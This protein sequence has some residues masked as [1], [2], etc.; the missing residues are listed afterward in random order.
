MVAFG[1]PA[2]R[3]E[4]EGEARQADG[5]G[6]RPGR[7][8]GMLVL[9]VEAGRRRRSVGQPVDR[10]VGD[11]VV[12]AQGVAEQ[13]A[14]PA[15]LPGRGV[16]QRVRDR[17]RLRL[18]QLVVDRVVDEALQEAQILQLLG[19]QAL[20]LGR[21]ARGE[22]EELVDVHPDDVLG[23]D[24]SLEGATMAPASLPWAPYR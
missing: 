15:D 13:L 24:S 11:D 3:P 8:L 20:E 21:V 1:E 18:L 6:G 14:A 12:L 19:G 7:L 5:D 16:G 23:V 2:D 10:D 9:V 4:V 17:L 22:G